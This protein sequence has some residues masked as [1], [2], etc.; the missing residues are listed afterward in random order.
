MIIHGHTDVIGQDAYNQN[1][2]AERATGAQKIIEAALAKA[3]TKNIKFETNGYGEDVS[4]SPFE[5]NLPEER[6]YN[7]TVILDIIPAK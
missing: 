3:G 6:F 1:L 4:T 5:N 2:S 7:R